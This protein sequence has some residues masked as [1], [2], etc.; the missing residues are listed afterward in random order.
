M[1]T[2]S[3]TTK[4]LSW[5]LRNERTETETKWVLE[6]KGVSAAAEVLG[7]RDHGQITKESAENLIPLLVAFYWL[8]KK[9]TSTYGREP[10]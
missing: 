9:D 4:S 1:G 6:S 8:K 10:A 2:V 5:T 3:T 7:G